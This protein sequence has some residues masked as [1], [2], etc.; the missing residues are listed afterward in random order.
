MLALSQRFEPIV[1]GIR[2]HHERWDGS[3]YPDG[4]EG[5][6][7]PLAGRIIAI[8]DTYDAMIKPRSYRQR[9]WT[10]DE[11]ID[12]LETQAHLQFDPHIVAVFVIANHQARSSRTHS[13]RT[14]SSDRRSVA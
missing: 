5:D 13:A 8:A 10:H 14:S 12:Q 7:I 11:V 4:L 1:S 2:S 9:T 3:G 6:A